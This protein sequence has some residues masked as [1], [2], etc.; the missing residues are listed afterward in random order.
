MSDSDAKPERCWQE[1]AAAAAKESNPEKLLE[2]SKELEDA[3]DHRKKVLR[4]T[5]KSAKPDPKKKSA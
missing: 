5:D 2:L 3:L 4:P 1:I